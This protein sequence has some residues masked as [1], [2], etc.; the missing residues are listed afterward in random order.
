MDD[1]ISHAT[2]VHQF[3][4]WFLGLEQKSER[5][6]CD[7]EVAELSRRIFRLRARPILIVAAMAL[8]VCPLVLFFNSQP[9]PQI[10]D[11]LIFAYGISLVFIGLPVVILLIR[12]GLREA[13]ILK[14]DL[15]FGRVFMFEGPMGEPWRCCRAVKGLLKERL[16]SNEQGVQ[17]RLDVLPVSGAV[18][19]ANGLKPHG[20]WTGEVVEATAPP[21]QHYD[22]PVSLDNTAGIAG[23]HFDVL[24]RHMSPGEIAELKYHIARIRRPPAMLI[25]MTVWTAILLTAMFAYASDGKLVQWLARFRTQA[26]LVSGIFAINAYRYTRAVRT[27]RLL[28]QDA[29]RQVLRIYKPDR[30]AMV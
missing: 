27:A 11:A 28:N 17:Q 19:V 25:V 26:L 1:G 4:R 20:W 24:Q 13:G 30:A 7:A 14:G 2:D 5:R 23:E 16:I 21:E 3:Q 6:L 10:P 18:I 29:S 9:Q 15:R 8:L 22:V 12:D